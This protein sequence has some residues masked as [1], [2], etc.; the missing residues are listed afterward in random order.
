MDYFFLAE[1]I[2]PDPTSLY[3]DYI[4]QHHGKLYCRIQDKH[5]GLLHLQS[6]FQYQTPAN[7]E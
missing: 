6:I 2:S 7:T 1:E 4:L 5:S 3:T